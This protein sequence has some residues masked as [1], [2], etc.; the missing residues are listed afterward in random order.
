MI[1]GFAFSDVD[2]EQLI[3]LRKVQV[4]Y[5]LADEVFSSQHL[6]ID[7]HIAAGLQL[8]VYIRY[9]FLP[10]CGRPVQR[11][12]TKIGRGKYL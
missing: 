8:F 11:A 10:A 3:D 5:L 4:V 12:Y 1:H 7:K 9:L 6:V 2:T